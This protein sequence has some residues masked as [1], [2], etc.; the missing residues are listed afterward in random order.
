MHGHLIHQGRRIIFLFKHCTIVTA[1]VGAEPEA[2]GGGVAGSYIYVHKNAA[3]H[4]YVFNFNLSRK[5]IYISGRG[6]RTGKAAVE[7]VNASLCPSF[8]E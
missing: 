4:G 6:T 8:E 1:V 7:C 3:K 2:G 5:K